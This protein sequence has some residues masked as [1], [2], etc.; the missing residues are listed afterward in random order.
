[1]KW[2]RII[3]AALALGLVGC[4]AACG[5]ETQNGSGQSQ[6]HPPQGSDTPTQIELVATMQAQEFPAAP[7][8]NV[9]PDNPYSMPFI[10]LYRTAVTT[11]TATRSMVV[12][13]PENISPNDYS[14]FVAAPS[15]VDTVAFL[16]HS[17]WIEV[18]DRYSKFLV[19]FEPENGQWGD[20]AEELDYLTKAFAAAKSNVYFKPATFNFYFAGYEDGG[21]LLHQFVMKTPTNC[22]GL[23]VMNGSEL[24]GVFLAETGATVSADPARALSDIEVPVWI[25]EDEISTGEQAV[26]N[27]WLTANHIDTSKGIVSGDTTIYRQSMSTKTQQMDDYPLGRVQV[28][29]GEC[30]YYDKALTNTLWSNF[31]SETARLNGIPLTTLRPQFDTQALGYE[32]VEQTVEGYSRYWLEY[33]PDSVVNS[34][35]PVP[36]VFAFGGDGQTPEAFAEQTEWHKVAEARDFIVVYPAAL[37]Y[38]RGNGKMPIPFWD[39]ANYEDQPDDFEF[40]RVIIAQLQDK[41]NVDMSRLYATGQSLG[42]QFSN[43]L[44]FYMPDVFCASALTGGMLVTDFL[45]DIMAN[46]DAFVRDYDYPILMIMEARG[47]AMD[48]SSLYGPGGA[49]GAAIDTVNYYIELNQTCALEEAQTYRTG[50]Y[51]HQVFSNGAGIP[52]IQYT[53]NPDRGHLAVPSETWTMYD[54]FLSHYARNTETHEIEYRSAGDNNPN[55]L[56]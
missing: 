49:L 18:A 40:L 13:V 22:A 14:I 48:Q 10:G 41:Y 21:T 8:Y 46:S 51:Y 43:L 3:T 31:L 36:I 25:F 34:E 20:E 53:I 42:G 9:D 26:V 17:G 50:S 28:T 12:Y 30:D 39:V 1:M 16:E 33:V 27:Y 52:L 5:G 32:K 37:P 6:S 19:A 15:G 54:N 2:K 35:I 45:D 29:V 38:D 47:N 11:E 24:D 4:L 23:V 55:F 7:Q 56:K 44:G